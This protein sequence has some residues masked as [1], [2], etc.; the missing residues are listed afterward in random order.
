MTQ[1]MGKFEWSND[2]AVLTNRFGE[3]RTGPTR[4]RGKFPSLS[5]ES[6]AAAVA[7][8]L[9]AVPVG[10]G[11]R[12]EVPDS[13]PSLSTRLPRNGLEGVAK[14]LRSDCRLRSTAVRGRFG[15]PP[16]PT[17]S[18]K[19]P[20]SF[21][22]SDSA[23]RAPKIPKSGLGYRDSKRLIRRC[24]P[25]DHHGSEICGSPRRWPCFGR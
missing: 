18:P 3:D 5:F 4:K 2:E 13:P 23:Q 9:M 16:P 21:L 24:P 6:L 22:R 7:V 20:L 8:A 15:V 10:Q 11:H 25:S 17:R 19:T 14:W 12:L 1:Q